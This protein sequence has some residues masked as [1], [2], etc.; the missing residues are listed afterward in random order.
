MSFGPALDNETLLVNASQD[1][2]SINAAIASGELT[3][4]VQGRSVTYRSI[5]D[6]LKAKNTI[7]SELA[8]QR[9]SEQQL[10]EISRMIDHIAQLSSQIT[11][12][13]TQQ[14]VVANDVQQSVEHIQQIAQTNLSNIQIVSDNSSALQQQAG[15]I[16]DMNKSFG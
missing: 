11:T 14:G 13:A 2:E 8:A 3:V 7:E 16:A 5:H 9:I 10:A 12:A 4:S 1:L 15:K 6:L